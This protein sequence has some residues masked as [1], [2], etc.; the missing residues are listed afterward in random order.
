MTET[1]TDDAF[2]RDQVEDVLAAFED[3]DAEAAS[4]IYAPDGVF[5]DPHYPEDE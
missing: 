1:Q 2:T 4:E 3:R 5:V